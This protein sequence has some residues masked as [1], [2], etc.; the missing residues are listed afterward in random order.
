MNILVSNDAPYRTLEQFAVGNDVLI[1]PAKEFREAMS[2]IKM[3]NP[4][5]YELL[6]VDYQ[7][8]CIR[9]TVTSIEFISQEEGK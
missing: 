2:V 8:E 6:K 3:L 7:Y 1:V 5:L 4:Q 9:S